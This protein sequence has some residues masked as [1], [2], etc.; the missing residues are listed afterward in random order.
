MLQVNFHIIRAKERPY[1][2]KQRKVKYSLIFIAYICKGNSKNKGNLLFSLS[3]KSIQE[4]IYS[5]FPIWS[6]KFS[7]HLLLQSTSFLMTP[8]KNV[9]YCRWSHVSTVYLTSSSFANQHPCNS[10]LSGAE[11]GNQI[12]WNLYCMLGEREAQI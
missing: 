5:L 7:T 1:N 9:F 11:Y 4:Q 12:G 8:V 6:P 3:Y 2:L 10:S